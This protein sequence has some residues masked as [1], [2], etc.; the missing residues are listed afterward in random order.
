M[1]ALARLGVSL[2]LAATL[3]GGLLVAILLL[4]P[5]REL[6]GEK[7]P[8]EKRGR[9]APALGPEAA[10]AKEAPRETPPEA[11]SPESRENPERPIEE[12]LL[13]EGE[14]PGAVY[15]MSRVREALRE[16]NPTFAR[17]LLRQM[18]EQHADSVLVTEAEDLFSRSR[19]RR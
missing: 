12:V 9:E 15:Y 14:D 2:L 4:G 5:K 13:E 8:V 3:T 1:K 6:P 7:A 19:R 10:V 11:P 16:G 18:K 17:E